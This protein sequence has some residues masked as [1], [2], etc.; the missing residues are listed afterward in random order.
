M[1]YIDTNNEERAESLYC[2]VFPRISSKEPWYQICETKK[3]LFRYYAKM[4]TYHCA[5]TNRYYSWD[6]NNKAY[7][8][9]E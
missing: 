8:M 9:D 7:L 2:K 3:D 5:H 1:V 4:D 6:S